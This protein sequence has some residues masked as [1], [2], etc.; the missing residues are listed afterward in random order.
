[1][2][3]EVRGGEVE[4]GGLVGLARDPRDFLVVLLGAIVPPA[5]ESGRLETDLVVGPATVDPDLRELVFPLHQLQA[6]RGL[7]EALHRL[8][9]VLGLH[10]RLQ[11]VLQRRHKC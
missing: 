8:G 2:R 10:P 3:G 6:Q 5:E 9:L 4:D 1:M 11:L 7:V